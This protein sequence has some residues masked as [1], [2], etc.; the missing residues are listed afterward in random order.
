MDLDELLVTEGSGKTPEG[1]A[2]KVYGKLAGLNCIGRLN[3]IYGYEI[4]EKAEY[5]NTQ[6]MQKYGDEIYGK[7]GQAADGKSLIQCNVNPLMQLPDKFVKEASDN[8][9]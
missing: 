6:L 7:S 2:V 4:T 9:G 8:G 3:F 5:A 1:K